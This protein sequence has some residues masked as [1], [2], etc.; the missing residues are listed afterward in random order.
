MVHTLLHGIRPTPS[1]SPPSVTD[2]IRNWHMDLATARA[3]IA[4][5]QERQQL[6]ANQHCHNISYEPGQLVAIATSDIK[7]RNLAATFK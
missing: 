7:I 1:H 3:S 4:T 6:Y 2:F 5:A